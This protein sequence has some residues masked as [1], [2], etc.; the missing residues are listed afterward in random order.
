MT[1]PPAVIAQV[2]AAGYVLVK[3]EDQ[4]IVGNLTID[5]AR[6]EMR[7]GPRVV[8]LSRHEACLA[9]AI[10]RGAFAAK[11]L[12]RAIYGRGDRP[13]TLAILIH[14]LRAKLKHLGANVAISTLH[15]VGYRM[16]TTQ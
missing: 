5:G 12:Y 4:A 11:D 13:D 14:R 7:A 10:A 8:S 3:A 6:R 9:L 15:G 1:L 2:H 16:E